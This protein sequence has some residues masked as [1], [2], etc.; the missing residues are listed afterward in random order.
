MRPVA[1]GLQNS[2]LSSLVIHVLRTQARFGGHMT[3]AGVKDIKDTFHG[4]GGTGPDVK[5]TSEEGHLASYMCT[6]QSD[7][8]HVVVSTVHM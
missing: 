4:P 2:N 3:P 6:G 7:R 8:S 1:Q 5:A